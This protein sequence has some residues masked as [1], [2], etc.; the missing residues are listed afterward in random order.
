M[1]NFLKTIFNGKAQAVDI[2]RKCYAMATV[3]GL[4][5]EITMYGEIVETVPVDWWTGE[6]VPGN[7]IELNEFLDDLEKISNAQ[8][9]TIRMNSVG[10]EVYA[11][12]LMYNRLDELKAT[13][14]V[15]VDGVAM[16][17]ASFIMC[18][19][20][21]VKVNAAS[22]VMIHKA[23]ARIFGGFNAD[24][25]EKIRDFLD[26]VDKALVSAYVKKTGK[27][28]EEILSL[29]SK[30][31]YM[32]GQ[33]AIDKGFADELIEGEKLSIAASADGGFLYINGK[34][35]RLPKNFSDIPKS[36]PTVDPEAGKPAPDMTNKKQPGGTGGIKGGTPMART[37]EELKKEDPELANALIAE[38]QAAV[39]S[40]AATNSAVEKERIRLKEIDAVSALFDDETVQAA[41]YGENTCTAQEMVYRAAQK[42]VTEGKQ[43]MADLADDSKQ[44]GVQK[45]KAIPGNQEGKE[46]TIE[47]MKTAGSEA[48][49]AYAQSMGG[50]KKDE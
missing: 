9:I 46:E 1:P 7:Y 27:S 49:K 33:E 18:V 23:S 8:N 26:T 2:S 10:G 24:E 5:A 36:I 43:F 29:M 17:A 15:I 44:S 4:N 48:G 20:D 40:E 39:S 35:V 19:A 30:T 13:I 6:P 22:I 14:T 38:A 37:L 12:L 32:T 21:T 45:V 25:I 28:E 31:T 16:S 11:A 42:A 34:A 3:D 47:D 41:K 50:K